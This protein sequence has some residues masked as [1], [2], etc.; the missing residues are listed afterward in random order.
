MQSHGVQITEYK[1]MY[2][3]FEIIEKV[4][5]KCHMCGKIDLMVGDTLG[6]HIKRAHKIKERTYKKT[7]C[8]NKPAAG[9]KKSVFGYKP[10]VN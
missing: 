1:A 10:L 8:I 4:F 5:H 3:Q 9:V 6:A 2:G 7:F